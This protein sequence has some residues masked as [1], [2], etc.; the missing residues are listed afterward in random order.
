[1]DN[2]ELFL[3]SSVLDAGK[4]SNALRLA[5]RLGALSSMAFVGSGTI[6]NHIL[7][8]LGITETRKD[9]VIAIAPK[10]TQDSF[11]AEFAKEFKL[12]TLHHGIA[13]AMPANYF[14]RIDGTEYNPE[15]TGKGENNMNYEAIYIIVNR[16]SIDAIVETAQEAGATGGT[17]LH[18][19]GTSK[20]E[21]IRF[22]DMDVEPEKELLLILSKKENTQKIITAIREKFQMDDYGKGI[23][24]V[25]EVAQTIGLYENNGEE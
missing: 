7:E 8:L 10:D 19:R 25:S 6:S 5:N 23:I 13:F 17:V 11:F 4:G 15:K 21:K 2:Q 16:G 14:Y 1:M 18:G 12:S 3:F 9:I 24:F 22:F 20:T